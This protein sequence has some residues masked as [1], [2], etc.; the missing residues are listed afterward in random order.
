MRLWCAAFAATV[1]TGLAAGGA[2]AGTTYA[3][4]DLG[5]LGYGVTHGLAING[6]GQIVADAYDTA[7]Y[8]THAL[9]LTPT[10]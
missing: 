2:Q 10:G 5:S 4:T 3:I 9:L 1:V 6:N 7:T 8:Q